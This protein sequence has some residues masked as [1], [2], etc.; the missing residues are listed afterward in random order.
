MAR[1]AIIGVGAIGGV[2]AALLRQAGRHDLTLCVRRPLE[3]LTV[4]TPES[5]V[6]IRAGVEAAVAV[7]QTKQAKRAAPE[8]GAL[9]IGSEE[10]GLHRL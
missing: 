1:I 5:P 10:R 4:E 6:R 7:D 2:I 3:S 8:L 9:V